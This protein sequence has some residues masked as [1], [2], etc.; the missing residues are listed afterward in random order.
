MLCA[1][2]FCLRWSGAA[3]WLRVLSCRKWHWRI[4]ECAY[5]FCIAR[6]FQHAGAIYASFALLPLHIKNAFRDNN[7]AAFFWMRRPATCRTYASDWQCQ[8]SRA[9]GVWRVRFVWIFR[10]L[11]RAICA[12][13]RAASGIGKFL[14]AIKQYG[15]LLP[16]ARFG[17]VPIISA[18]RKQLA[19]RARFL[20]RIHP[21]FVGDHGD[22]CAGNPASWNRFQRAFSPA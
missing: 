9:F 6:D 7:I 21:H 1:K 2:V 10:C 8:T 19:P 5:V 16:A 18:H 3:I 22:S 13:S 17:N 15:E 20:R 4:R 11:N 14:F 12:Q